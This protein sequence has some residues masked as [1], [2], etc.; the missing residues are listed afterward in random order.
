MRRSVFFALAFAA[1]FG[2]AQAQAFDSP[3]A[4]LAA[5]YEPY[6]ANEIPEDQ[7]AFFSAE[8]NALYA[9]DAENTPEG[10]MGAL[11]FDPYI[12]GQD[13]D[14]G[15]FA[16]GEVEDNGDWATAEVSFTNFGEPRL[17]T[18]DLVFEDGGWLIDDVAG[19]NPDFS[20]R[21]SD[22]LSGAN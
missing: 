14:L 1:A 12:D 5:F 19:E 6:L 9:A 4:L 10:E 21:L 22:I 20:Y 8:L 16:I 3:Q 2:T 18:Y 7:S 17:L 11:D 15:A 13:W